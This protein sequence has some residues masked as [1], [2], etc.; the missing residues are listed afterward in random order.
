MT[1]EGLYSSESA[2]SNACKVVD[3]MQEAAELFA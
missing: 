3:R 1:Q 2:L